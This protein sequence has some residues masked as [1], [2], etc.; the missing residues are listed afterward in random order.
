MSS[1][2]QTICVCRVISSSHSLQGRGHIASASAQATQ[3]VL[4]VLKRH[5]Y[6]VALTTMLLPLL[7]WLAQGF[8]HSVSGQN[9]S[10]NLYALEWW[11]AKESKS[12]YIFV[13]V[14]SFLCCRRHTA[15]SVR[16]TR[17]HGVNCGWIRRLCA[18]F[19]CCQ[20]LAS[21]LVA[22]RVESTRR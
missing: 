13:K 22:R 16:K 17:Q 9:P 8:P 12:F 10:C 7:G 21:K 2:S 5:T 14:S 3:L 11:P 20:C 19:T 1:L 6:T 18:W 4:F 15:S